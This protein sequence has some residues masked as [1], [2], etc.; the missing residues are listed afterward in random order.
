M[1]P[2]FPYFGSK[3]TLAARI[4]AELPEH[5]HYVEPYAGSLAVLLA[6]PLAP[7]ETVNDLDGDLVTFWRVLREQPAEL[8]RVCALTPHARAEYDAAG[9]DR[10]CLPDLERAR[11]VWVKLTQG[12]GGTLRRS[13]WRQYVKPAGYTSV[14]G[15]LDGYV[16][17]MAV[18]AE[19][20]HAVSLEC[21]PALDVI[22]RYGRHPEVLLYVDPP[23]LSSTRAPGDESRAGTHRYQHEMMTADAHA[24]LLEALRGCAAAVAV[25]GYP[26]ELY[27]ATLR[28]WRRVEWPA[29]TGQSA[30]GEW[31]TRTEALWINR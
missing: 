19:R 23:Y 28:D 14:P 10:A 9:G 13:G 21:R 7:F 16:D 18:A 30:R 11:Q 8:A 29:G 31:S 3:Q 27:G 4:I 5:R 2:P 15:Y 25:S 20:L 22:D 12:R 24:Q 1:R 26:S 17:R 6:K